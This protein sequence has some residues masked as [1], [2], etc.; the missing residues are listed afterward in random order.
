MEM[1]IICFTKTGYVLA[2]R[3][4]KELLGCVSENSN[5][6]IVNYE[7][8][9]EKSDLPPLSAT[10]ESFFKKE[11]ILFI[12]ACGI[13][14][15]GIAPFIK[16]KRTDPAVLVMDEKGDF[17]IP[18]LS[19]HLGGANELGRMIA[20]GIG[21]QPVLT[22]ATDVNNKFAIDVFAKKNHMYIVSME[23]MR[24]FS[25]AL[26]RGGECGIL[27]SNHISQI[28]KEKPFKTTAVLVPQN[29]YLGIGCRKGKAS[30]ELEAFVIETLKKNDISK[31][32]VAGIA[33]IDFKKEEQAILD[34]AE[35]F[36]CETFFYDSE[37]LKEAKGDF[38][39]SDFVEKKTGVSNV[40]ERSAS[41]ASKGGRQLLGK[42]AKDGMTIAIY[43][44]KVKW[45]GLTDDI[46]WISHVYSEC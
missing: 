10:I 43:E 41:I 9:N 35:K 17:V 26:L 23:E 1:G 37:T 32:S 34:L 42:V 22:T 2:E 3:V 4:K 28:E 25:A 29:I 13:A 7:G 20:Q 19:G 33:S 45:K 27:F 18:I 30:Q 36:D 15:R 21:G 46:Q 11:A 6:E 5:I 16:D 39:K 12:G 14:V 24:L 38:A 44:K 31:E 8:K 40:C